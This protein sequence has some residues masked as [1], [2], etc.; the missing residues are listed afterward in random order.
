MRNSEPPPTY[1]AAYPFTGR[2]DR[3][4]EIEFHISHLLIWSGALNA[5]SE[6]LENPNRG[7]FHM[8]GFHGVTPETETTSHY[9]WS[10]A[11]NPAHD[12]EV[13]KTK[14]V[15]QTVLTF[16]ED[17]KV[18]E[19]QYANTRRFG[20]GAMVDLHIDVGANRARRIINQLCTVS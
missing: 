4:Q 8:R 20:E 1:T 5:G 16:D 15:E 9:F 7:G 14:V 18:I 10:I 17:K 13:I 2:V 6:P 11:T 3:W 12:H 19:S